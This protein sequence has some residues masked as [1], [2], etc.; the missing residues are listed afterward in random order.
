MAQKWLIKAL[1]KLV[2]I[3]VRTLRHYDEIGLLKPSL[4]QSNGYRVYSEHDLSKLHLIKTL[5]H[6]GL[7]LQK[8]KTFLDG[9]DNPIDCLLMQKQALY[10]N[11]AKM[12]QA[13]ACLDTVIAQF[14][15]TNQYDY[16][17]ITLLVEGYMTMIDDLKKT[18]A[19]SVFNDEQLTKFAKMHKRLKGVSQ[20]EQDTYSKAWE[21][22]VKEVTT[23]T[24]EDPY[25]P[26]GQEYAKKWMALVNEYWTDRELGDAIWEAY[27]Q[28]KIPRGHNDMSGWPVIP[29]EVIQWIDKAVCFMYSG[30]KK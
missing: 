23:K 14:E 24:H 5:K 20:E 25:G 15:N 22:L 11:I 17:N 3:S 16:N 18:W 12:K 26:V 6:F 29:Q 30:Q 10:A 8:I 19:G 2:G 9:H 27:K 1:S 13:A 7:R 4:R 21:T 28:D